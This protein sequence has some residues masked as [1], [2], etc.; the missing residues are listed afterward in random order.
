MSKTVAIVD[1]HMGN[2]LSIKRACEVVGLNAII[3]HDPDLIQRAAGL[4]LPGVGAFGDAMQHLE[5]LNLIQPIR[6]FVDSG[7][8]LLGICLGMQLLMTRSEEFGEHQGLNIIPGDVIRFP[9]KANGVERITIP[10][11]QWNRVVFPKDRRAL[12][13]K[14]SCFQKVDDQDYMYFVHSYYVVPW[15]DNV[16]ALQSHYQGVDYCSALLWKNVTATQFHP[17]QSAAKGI[18]IYRNWAR[19]L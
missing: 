12:I 17:E 1:F 10:Q 15:D 9:D 3:T 18:D 6:Q 2:L 8:P 5:E 11:V 14:D 7:K 19:L 13:K 4:V 16:I